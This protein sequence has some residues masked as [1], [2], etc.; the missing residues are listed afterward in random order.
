M[1]V[2][3]QPTLVLN[4]NWSPIGVQVVSRALC[5]VFSQN[6]KIIDPQDYQQYTWEDWLQMQPSD[7]DP[8][9]RLIGTT[10]RVPEVISL[11][12][13]SGMKQHSIVFNR[14]N[15]FERDKYMCQY[16]GT[17]LNS[18]DVTVDHIVPRSQ[19]GKSSWSNCVL[20]CV[21]C[22]WK[23]ADKTL[24]QSGMKL[25]CEPS[26]PKWNP[27]FRAKILIPSWEKFLSEMYWTVPIHE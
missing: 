14:R 9:I 4:K 1:T 6:A 19:G 16:C 11:V 20:A 17:H 10:I 15:L 24:S 23:K 8:T 2:L 26:K 5:L 18:K 25:L 3:A 22:N 21:K 7:D 27:I 12:N 13:Y